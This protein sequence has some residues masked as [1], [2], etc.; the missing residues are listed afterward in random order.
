M[1]RT[2][3]LKGR[4]FEEM[5]RRFG[6]TQRQDYGHVEGAMLHTA[7][8]RCIHCGEAA[9]CKAWME[10]TEGVAGAADFCPNAAAFTCLARRAAKQKA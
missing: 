7:A 1:R 6:V 5:L 2:R 4:L 9:R 10:Q 8:A 3:E